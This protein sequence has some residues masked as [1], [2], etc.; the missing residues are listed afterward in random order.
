MTAASKEYVDAAWEYVCNRRGEGE[1]IT[2]VEVEEFKRRVLARAPDAIRLSSLIAQGR[3]VRL[4]KEVL[5]ES[6]KENWSGHGVDSFLIDLNFP[7]RPWPSIRV[8]EAISTLSSLTQTEYAATCEEMN[9][10]IKSDHDSHP[11]A[12]TLMQLQPAIIHSVIARHKSGDATRSVLAPISAN[13]DSKRRPGKRKALSSRTYQAG[14]RKRRP[15]PPQAE[16][17]GTENGPVVQ[18]HS[19]SRI[20][21]TPPPLSDGSGDDGEADDFGLDHSSSDGHD[22]PSPE[23]PR[24]A[25]T[26]LPDEPSSPQ[27]DDFAESN[28]SFNLNSPPFA[29][30]LPAAAERTPLSP[31]SEMSEDGRSKHQDDIQQTPNW[32]DGALEDLRALHSPS[33]PGDTSLDPGAI[34][35][36]VAAPSRH[37]AQVKGAPTKMPHS[38]NEP[39]KLEDPA[40]EIDAIPPSTLLGALQSLDARSMLISTA[41]EK[42]LDCSRVKDCLALDPSFLDADLNVILSR[43]KLKNLD[44]SHPILV[45]IQSHQHWSMT[46]TECGTGTTYWYS[47]L[48]LRGHER[49]AMRKIKAFQQYLKSHERVTAQRDTWVIHSVNRELQQ[50]DQE[51]C[52]IFSLVWAL[53]TIHGCDI[54]PQI[55]QG[56]WRQAFKA[57][58]DPDFVQKNVNVGAADN[59]D[60]SRS[61]SIPIFAAQGTPA[62]PVKFD[63][64]PCSILQPALCPSLVRLRADRSRIDEISTS[65]QTNRLNLER[66]FAALEQRLRVLESSHLIIEACLQSQRAQFDE[67]GEGEGYQARIQDL[68][69]YRQIQEIAA[70]INVPAELNFTLH[71]ASEGIRQIKAQTRNVDTRRRCVSGWERVRTLWEVEKD[72]LEREKARKLE[73]RTMLRHELGGFAEAV[74]HLLSAVRG[75]MKHTETEA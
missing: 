32:R 24:R 44:P 15:S 3:Q 61:P 54:P 69:R 48:D 11:K 51:S 56:F 6:I 30:S 47:S 12:G 5:D 33:V 64:G 20:H 34:F 13:V 28:L 45:P 9:T 41:I 63:V 16:N 36:T 19:P 52:G 37:L 49:Q 40:A 4:R 39:E 21:Q 17:F 14:A 75:Q 25:V 73:E 22:I 31:I 62:T 29:P 35:D 70:A 8:L 66:D 38:R 57:L 55:S 71:S 27:L 50:D 23:L 2:P 74:E 46:L 67:I 72:R 7:A 60:A 18:A 59:A 42:V 10:A 68:N 43:D 26:P 1:E 65:I 58:L 53:A